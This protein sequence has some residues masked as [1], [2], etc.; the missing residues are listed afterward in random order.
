MNPTGMEDRIKATFNGS[1]LSMWASPSP[2]PML[3]TRTGTIK[4]FTPA[5][6]NA[7]LKKVFTQENRMAIPMETRSKKAARGIKTALKEA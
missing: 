5:I 4:N 1:P 2:Y 7:G 6:I 3:T